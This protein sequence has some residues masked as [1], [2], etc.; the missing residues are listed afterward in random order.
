MWEAREAEEGGDICIIMANSSMA[1]TITVL[2][3]KK[4]FSST[5][6]LETPEG[7]RSSSSYIVYFLYCFK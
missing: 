2:K 6:I 1:E 5:A 3:K 7:E 4:S